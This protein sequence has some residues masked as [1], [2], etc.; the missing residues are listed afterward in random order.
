MQFEKVGEGL[1]GTIDKAETLLGDPALRSAV[2]NLN[3]TLVQVEELAGKLNTEANPL[4]A[5]AADDL[6]KV[7]V[8]LDEATEALTALKSQFEPNS[9]LS[10]ELVSTLDQ[11]GQ[12]LEALRELAQQIQRDP[13]SLITGK[14]AP[15]KTP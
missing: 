14:P 11:A 12:A 6:K 10:R 7:G 1:V 13:S 15:T 2:S 9:T 5:S 3:Q 8:A 4:L